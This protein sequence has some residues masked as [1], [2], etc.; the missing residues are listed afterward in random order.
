MNNPRVQR[1]PRLRSMQLHQCAAPVIKETLGV[2]GPN[3]DVG[4]DG[5]S[6]SKRRYEKA[7]RAGMNP[8]QCLR[9][10]EYWVD[11]I[12]YCHGHA[13]MV[14]LNILLNPDDSVHRTSRRAPRGQQ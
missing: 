6:M 8:L 3:A 4:P 1:I 14:A 7:V 12:G 10:A 11:E 2:V 5:V 13:S 9:W